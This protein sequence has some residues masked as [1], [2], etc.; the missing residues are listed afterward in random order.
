MLRLRYMQMADVPQVMRIESAAFSDS[1]SARSYY[2]EINES[3]VSYMVVL[4][5]EVPAA[6]SQTNNPSRTTWGRWW[7]RWRSTQQAT[8]QVEWVILG[9]GGL[10]RVQDEAH[11]STIASDPQQRRKGYGEALLLGMILKAVHLGAEYVVLEVRV[12]NTSAQALYLKH[13]FE[14]TSVKPQYY[15]NNLEDAYDMRLLNIQDEAVQARLRTAY[16]DL[17]QRLNL[18]DEY[19]CAR[20]PRLG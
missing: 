2:F 20:H 11:I 15:Q 17:S 19:T 6:T 18:Q 1:W 13:G 12:S 7:A 10:W 3:L 9:Y 5:G 14:I 4:E 8:Q 16:A